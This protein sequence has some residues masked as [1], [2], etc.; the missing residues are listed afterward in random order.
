[1]HAKG[2]FIGADA[3]G[4]FGVV[5]EFITLGVE[6][7]DR[8]DQSALV[9]PVYSGGIGNVVNWIAGGIEFDALKSRRQEA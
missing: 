2:H 4:D 7:L 6:L 1:M 8:L 5:D 3:G 9:R